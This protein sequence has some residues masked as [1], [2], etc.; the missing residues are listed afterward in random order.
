MDTIS[1]LSDLPPWQI[2][3]H[4]AAWPSAPGLTSIVS[5]VAD[6]LYARHGIMHV[7]IPDPDTGGYRG[8]IA[9]LLSGLV[10]DGAIVL[11]TQPFA[12]GAPAALDEIDLTPD[13]VA[14]A[15]ANGWVERAHAPAQPTRSWVFVGRIEADLLTA[16]LEVDSGTG[17]ADALL[18][19]LRGLVLP[20]LS[21]LAGRGP[22]LPEQGSA[23]R[24]L[25]WLLPSLKPS[26]GDADR[27]RLA[28]AVAPWLVERFDADEGR[29]RTREDFQKEAAAAF[30]PLM[31]KRIFERVWSAATAIR[32]DRKVAG[33]RFAP[34]ARPRPTAPTQPAGPSRGKALAPNHHGAEPIEA[35]AEDPELASASAAYARAVAQSGAA[36]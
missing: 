34:G 16:I 5:A 8:D 17:D 27:D 1:G 15:I 24:I 18:T 30:A 6:A 19:R 9:A 11:L 25:A 4:D 28:N 31:T 22:R 23:E 20:Q 2:Y 12:G 14:H 36:A 35:P 3:L 21:L 7:D 13:L 10:L 32:T 33:R 29:T 26:L